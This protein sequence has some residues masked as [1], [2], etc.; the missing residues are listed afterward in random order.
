MEQFI[1]EDREPFEETAEKVKKYCQ[2]VHDITS[3]K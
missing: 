1:K 2:C 3:V